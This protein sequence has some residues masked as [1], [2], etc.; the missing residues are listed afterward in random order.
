MNLF[1][2]LT[3]VDEKTG[4]FEAVAA[5]EALDRSQE[6]FDYAKSKPHFQSWSQNISKATDGKSVGNVRA[7]HGKVAAGKLSQIDFD[8]SAKAI[9][10]AGFAVDANEKQKLCSGV[11]SGLSIGGQYGE[12]WDDPVIKGATRYEAIPSEISLVDYPCNP[13]ASFT[14]VKSD[15]AEELRKFVHSTGDAESLA[16]WYE[17]LSDEDKASIVFA[18]LQ[19]SVRKIAE[20][21][22][23]NPKEGKDKYGDV[24]F[25]DEKNK[26]YPIDTAAHIRAAWNYINKK[27]NAAKYDAEDVKAI[28]S[29]IIAA[30][31]DKI[32]KDGPPSAAKDT[33]SEKAALF[34]C[35]ASMLFQ[36]GEKAERL[37]KTIGDMIGMKKGLYSVA[38]LANLLEQ[39]DQLADC[40]EFEAVRD[41][42]GSPIA[43]ELR[44]VV[45]NLGQILCRMCEE[46]VA[47]LDDNDESP[48]GVIE[49]NTQDLLGKRGAKHSAE[50]RKHHEEIGKHADSI[51]EHLD[52]LKSGNAD[53]KEGDENE[54]AMQ[55][56]LQKNADLEK[57]VGEL[58]A[59]NEKL[60]KAVEDATKTITERNAT[61]EKLSAEP[62]LVKAAALRVMNK[63]EDFDAGGSQS[64]AEVIKGPDG[65]EDQVLTKLA[66]ALKNPIIR[67]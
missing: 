36:K 28:K 2:R 52:A 45:N 7:M 21:K 30:W 18:Q 34:D 19:G 47:E 26:K 20:R 38:S 40:E 54:K 12:K 37:A 53:D 50:T 16:K 55:A 61:I 60:I 27:K 5:S 63:G 9:K 3:K 66:H 29:R 67:R 6:I 57:L 56:S 8:D 17:T 25:A 22:D 31:K 24:K 41:H 58:N 44:D 42:D 33:K 14:V 64:S 4:Y 51:K 39:L 1:A 32:D 48:T 59:R 65:K 62:A 13:E 43:G 46:E 49:M 23:V 15:G 35:V 11:Y 10:V